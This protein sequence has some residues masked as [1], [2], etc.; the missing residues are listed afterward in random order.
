MEQSE[1]NKDANVYLHWVKAPVGIITNETA[2]KTAKQGNKN[3][4]T[5]LGISFR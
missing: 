1:L 3:Y 4:Q 5:E 2:D